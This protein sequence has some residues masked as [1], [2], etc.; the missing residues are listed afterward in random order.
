MFKLYS[1]VPLSFVDFGLDAEEGWELHLSLFFVG[2][3]SSLC[4]IMCS[5]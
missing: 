5:T 2:T 3:F 1:A 4:D